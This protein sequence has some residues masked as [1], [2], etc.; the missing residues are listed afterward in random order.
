MLV[1]LGAQRRTEG[2]VGTLL[3]CHERIR[4]FLTLARAVGER[5]ATEQERR[6]ACV[7]CRRYFVEAL[8]L[9]VA[10][11][12]LSILPRL[13]GKDAALDAALEAMHEQHGEHEPLLAR[14]LKEL[15]SVHAAPA[16][17][18][19]RD[20]LLAATSLL[21]P[22]LEV[23]LVGEE[24]KVFPALTA[25]L[26]SAEQEAIFAELRKRRAPA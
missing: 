17:R 10:D 12:E 21:E 15:E 16:D 11:E 8:P 24:S 4:S 3:A 25:L 23:H 2:L 1:K 20:R 13:R 22:A 19:A 26:S 7:S 6:E 9:H 14:F 5:E 18:A